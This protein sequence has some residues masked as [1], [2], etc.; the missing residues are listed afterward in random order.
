MYIATTN[1]RCIGRMA[2]ASFSSLR[3]SSILVP[4]AAYLFTLV[5]RPCSQH[6][7]LITT[8]TVIATLRGFSCH[9]VP[10]YQSTFRRDISSE[11][12][13]VC[14]GLIRLQ[15]GKAEERM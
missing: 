5:L 1:W 15:F 4:P 10:N 3:E 11:R 6:D 9:D 12:F 2:G 7:A 8:R 13:F 14:S